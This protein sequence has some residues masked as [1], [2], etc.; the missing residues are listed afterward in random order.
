MLFRSPAPPVRGPQPSEDQD[1]VFGL[2]PDPLVLL[3]APLL[4]LPRAL[5]RLP[6]PHLLQLLLPPPLLILQL[7]TGARQ[8]APRPGN[9]HGRRTCARPAD[10]RMAYGC[11]RARSLDT[12]ARARPDRRNTRTRHT[13]TTDEYA[14]TTRARLR[15]MCTADRRARPSDTRTRQT[16][17][18]TDAHANDTGYE[19]TRT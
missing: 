14:H 12:R 6:C 5:L 9:A 15:H 13:C 16:A 7:T 4:L 17:R 1:L 18:P 11:A 3:P 8:P 19:H 2:A 10:T